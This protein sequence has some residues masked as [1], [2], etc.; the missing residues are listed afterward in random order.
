M[1]KNTDDY[2]NLDKVVKLAEKWEKIYISKT[3]RETASFM[4]GEGSSPV[5]PRTGEPSWEKL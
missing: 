4:I 1:I 5:M 3:D 2:R